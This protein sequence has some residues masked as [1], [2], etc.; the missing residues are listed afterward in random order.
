MD[1]DLEHPGTPSEDR[2]EER[3]LRQLRREH[4]PLKLRTRG[5]EWGYHVVWGEF[6]AGDVERALVEEL[7]A[8]DGP[9]TEEHLLDDP[10]TDLFADWHID[11]NGREALAAYLRARGFELVVGPSDGRLDGQRLTLLSTPEGSDGS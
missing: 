7:E 3:D 6:K 4:S 1:I 8:R 5:P 2:V 9:L 10:V 11:D